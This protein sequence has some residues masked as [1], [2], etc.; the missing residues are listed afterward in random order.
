MK[1]T[2]AFALLW[3]VCLAFVPAAGA[4]V[5]VSPDTVRL[6]LAAGEQ[7]EMA[8]T[9]T[10]KGAGTLAL[11]AVPLPGEEAV[12]ESGELLF[13]TAPGDA[14]YPY[15][16]AMTD[17]G[18]LFAM[19]VVTVFNRVEVWEYT[20]ELEVV[21]LFEH[22]GLNSDSRVSVT[23]MAWMPSEAPPVYEQ[24]T[25]WW[26]ETVRGDYDPSECL[27]GLEEAVLVETDLDDVATGRTI[28]LSIPPAPPGSDDIYCTSILRS[29]S[30]ATE[31]GLFYYLA[32]PGADL[33][34]V[35]LGGEVAAGYPVP[36]TDYESGSSH[37][38]GGFDISSHAFDLALGVDVGNG[39][40]QLWR[41]VVT[42]LDGTSTGA[43]TPLM[44]F[45]PIDPPD[46]FDVFG[47]QRSQSDPT[48]L[49]LGVMNNEADSDDDGYWIYAVR[50]H[51][52]PP[53]WL[54]VA[55]LT[56]D[57]A[58]KQPDTLAVRLDASGLEP[59][60]Y[61]GAVALR[62]DGPNGE[63]QARVPVV[64]TVTPGTSAEP[65]TGPAEAVLRLLAPYPNPSRGATTIPLMLREAAEVR[66]VVFDVLGREVAVLH[67]GWLAAG[68]H[69]LDF[70]GSALPAGLY[71][72][73][74]GAR[75]D[76]SAHPLTRRL[77]LTR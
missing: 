49:Y 56:L 10:N 6:S 63:A 71:L 3:S 8:L 9:V 74:A 29:L 5:V 42:D 24:G 11:S 43:E 28:P 16:L 62:G 41:V 2:G 15:D 12:G 54:R 33:Y 61:E 32:E 46:R 37:W 36:V 57:V 69:R 14:H 18:R 68:A 72:V 67:K 25:L 23:G 70:D 22:A 55:P 60:V 59:G 13:T 66:V 40:D 65:P 50:A 38:L 77:V 4:Q 44:H 20:P 34:A 48:M 35:G 7:A 51:P 39:W 58:P 76:R 52:F 27:S 75:G 45:A 26:L 21:R 17:T 47:V 73:R 31:T 64:L 19:E 1:A 30:Y 53:P